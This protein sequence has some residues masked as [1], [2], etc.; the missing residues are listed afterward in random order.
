M[1]VAVEYISK[2]ESADA[3]NAKHGVTGILA[4]QGAFAE[5]AAVLTSSVRRGNCCAQP[6]ISMNPSTA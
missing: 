3:K 2:E 1:V 6:R 5:H 4:V